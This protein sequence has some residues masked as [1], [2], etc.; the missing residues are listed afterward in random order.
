MQLHIINPD[1]S[2]WVFRWQVQQRS[3]P[4]YDM[5]QPA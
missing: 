5:Q 4:D 2:V 3:M 1:L